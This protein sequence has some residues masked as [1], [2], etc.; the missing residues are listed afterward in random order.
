MVIFTKIIIIFQKLFSQCER[1]LT[2][3]ISREIYNTRYAWVVLFDI[4]LQ[5]I[6]EIS[7]INFLFTSAFR[8]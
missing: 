1:Q 6:E 4:Y 7:K 3:F 5:F 2:D 8:M